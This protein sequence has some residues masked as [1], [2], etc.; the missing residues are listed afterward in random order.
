MKYKQRLTEVHKELVEKIRV[1]VAELQHIPEVLYYESDLE[2]ISC[3]ID[4]VDKIQK[5]LNDLNNS[6]AEL[7]NEDIS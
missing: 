4:E 7:Y 1:C 2:V 6:L 3:T 5:I